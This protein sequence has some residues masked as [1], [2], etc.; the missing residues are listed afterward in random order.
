MQGHAGLQRQHPVPHDHQFFRN[1]R[2]AWDA[3]LLGNLSLVDSIV[4]YHV[5]VL[6]VTEDG[7]APGA[8]LFQGF[9]HEGGAHDG[10]TVVGERRRTGGFQGGE[11]VQLLPLLSRRHRCDGQ[12]ADTRTHCFRSLQHILH[13]LRRVHHR[14]GVGHTGNGS[15]AAGGG[16]SS[17]GLD[18]LLLGLPG[19]TEVNMRVD[20]TRRHAKTGGIYADAVLSRSDVRGD[21][22]NRFVFN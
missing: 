22:C 21:F 15:K 8:G 5:L 16:S 18:V 7:H 14:F 2:A 4:L 3:Q 1:G 6:L 13:Q 11:V 10:H 12:D 20:E 17:A 9:P 19:V